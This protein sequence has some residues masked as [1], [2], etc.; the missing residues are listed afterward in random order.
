MANLKRSEEF[1]A[2]TMIAEPFSHSGKIF[3]MTPRALD[4]ALGIT[5]GDDDRR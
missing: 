5:D 4:C 1:Q 2:R 3:Q